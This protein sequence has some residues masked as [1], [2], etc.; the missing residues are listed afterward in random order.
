MNIHGQITDFIVTGFSDERDLSNL[1]GADDLIGGGIVDSMGVLQIVTFVEKTFGTRV[2]DDEITLKNFRTID[3][4][5]AFVAQKTA[6]RTQ[7][8]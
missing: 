6:E 2:A 7:V 3:A 4:I 5:A 1:N 8:Q